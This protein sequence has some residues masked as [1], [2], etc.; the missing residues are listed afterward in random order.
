MSDLTKLAAYLDSFHKGDLN[1][2]TACY[3]RSKLAEDFNDRETV[4]NGEDEQLEDTDVTMSTPEQQSE[5]NTEGDIMSGAFR[6][7]DV[8]NKLKEEKEKIIVDPDSIDEKI[9]MTERSPDMATSADFGANSPN[10]KKASLFEL[11][12]SKLSK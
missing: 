3:L 7:L 4:N 6:E 8:Q 9:T 2:D 12:Q 5:K 1:Y 10:Y 11:L